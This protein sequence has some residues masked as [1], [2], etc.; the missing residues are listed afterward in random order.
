MYTFPN[1]KRYIGKTKRSLSKRQRSFFD[2][3]KNC[4]AL[5]NAI[6][7]Y[8]VENIEQEILFEREMT[9][10]EASRLEQICILT[11]QT[12]ANRFNN[13]KQGYNLTDGGEGLN[14]WKPDEERYEA[15]V[16]QMHEFH[17]KR[18]GTHHS[19]EA[20]RKMSEAKKGEK[21]PNYGKH[22][23][24][25]RKR[26]IGLANSRENMSE[27]TKK[28]RSAAVK[29]K[30]V[31]VHNETGEE[32][33]FESCEK[34]AEYFGVRSS[35]ITRWAH[36]TRIPRNNNYTFKIYPRTTTKRESVA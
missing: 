5:W 7:K 24:E 36:S 2:G 22:F 34:A 23:S 3:Y 10:E 15:L 8:G 32:L 6:Q 16:E 27:E 9:D 35:S 30:V 20:K 11:F 21:H 13:P 14:G 33:V 26:K 4:T 29:K 18:R 12:N 25:E 17:E 19:E 28:R 31:A 1:G